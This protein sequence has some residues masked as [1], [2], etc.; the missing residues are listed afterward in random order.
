MCSVRAR[1]GARPGSKSPERVLIT[2]PAVG[3]KPMLVSM[4]L[5]SRTVA[6]L[7]PLPRCARITRPFV[8][9][10]SA[11]PRFT[12][13]ATMTTNLQNLTHT[14]SIKVGKTI[15]NIDRNH[16]ASSIVTF[17]HENETG[18]ERGIRTPDTAFDR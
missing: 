7:A 16:G 4:L 11:P 1:Y 12:Q 6:M 10:G 2:N 18:G 5:P 13:Q 8:A 9:V 14:T 3:V 17:S 15:G